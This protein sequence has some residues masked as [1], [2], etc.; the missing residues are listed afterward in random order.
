MKRHR[1]SFPSCHGRPWWR[2][3][4]LWREDVEEDALLQRERLQH[5]LAV[6]RA[7]PLCSGAGESEYDGPELNKMD[8]HVRVQLP[9]QSAKKMVRRSCSSEFDTKLKAALEVRRRVT[10]IV[11]RDVV[12]AAEQKVRMGSQASAS[13]AS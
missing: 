4:P 3:R 5:E 9:D 13:Q 8:V 6:L 2:I 12:D 11:G 1:T 10:D 7:I